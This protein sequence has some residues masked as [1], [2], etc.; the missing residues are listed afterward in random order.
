MGRAGSFA[1]GAGFIVLL[2]TFFYYLSPDSALWIYPLSRILGM[3]NSIIMVKSVCLKGD[4][5]W[6]DVPQE[7]GAFLRQVYCILPSVKALLG[8][9]TM[10]FMRIE[11]QDRLSRKS[12]QCF[13][14]DLETL[15]A[16]SG[17]SSR[18]GSV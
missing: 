11:G 15:Q 8:L 6:Q 17:T 12:N 16:G 3:N 4:L 7:D 10:R 14:H 1:L 13:Q 2:L 9:C 18:Y 5:Q